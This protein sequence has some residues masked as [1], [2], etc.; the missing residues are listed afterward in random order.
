MATRVYSGILITR[1]TNRGRAVINFNT[2]TVS[3]DLG[4]DKHRHKCNMGGIGEFE[5]TPCKMVAIREIKIEETE[6]TRGRRHEGREIDYLRV[7][8][9]EI[10]SHRLEISWQFSGGSQIEEISYMVIGSK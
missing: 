3:G 7:N 9:S 1:G 6:W 5:G 4:E 2:H 8:D 10:N